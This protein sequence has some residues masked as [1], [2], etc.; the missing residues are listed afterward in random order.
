MSITKQDYFD[1]RVN[2]LSQIEDLKNDLKQLQEDSSYDAD[3]N[4][5][6][7][8]KATIKRVNKAAALEVAEKYEDY[9][10]EV[11]GV[12]E[13]FEELTNYNG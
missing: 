3:T 8:D 12:M 13:E 9:R 4:P 2:L 5:K 6:G 11:K 7:L 1:R 10:E